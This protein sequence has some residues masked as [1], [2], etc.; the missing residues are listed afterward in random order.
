[1]I[2]SKMTVSQME[3]KLMDQIEKTKSKLYQL[4][5]KHKLEIGNLAYQYGLNQLNTN[6]LK[7]AFSKI[8]EENKNGYS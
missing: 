2:M 3:L 1:M 7:N 8:A 6:Q 5:Q 4:Q